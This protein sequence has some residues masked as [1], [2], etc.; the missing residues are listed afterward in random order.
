MITTIIVIFVIGTGGG[1]MLTYVLYMCNKHNLLCVQIQV[2]P[3]TEYIV[4]F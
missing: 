1:A 2:A 3:S 4:V